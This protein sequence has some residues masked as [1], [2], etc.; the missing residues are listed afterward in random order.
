MARMRM[1]RRLLDQLHVPLAAS[2]VDIGG[3]GIYDSVAA[4]L[5]GK[6]ERFRR[7]SI[8]EKLTA[9]VSGM[10]CGHCAGAVT[11]ALT[12]VGG[13][14]IEKVEVGSAKVSYDPAVTSPAAINKAIEDA[15]FEVIA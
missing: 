15:G 10:S 8:M 11:R 3:G 2:P 5:T 9:R 4:Y 12:S 14:D 1:M 7:K 6:A 13:V